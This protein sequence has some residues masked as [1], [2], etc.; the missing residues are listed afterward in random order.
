[1]DTTK[2]TNSVE[3]DTPRMVVAFQCNGDKE[4]YRWGIV[5]TMPVLSLIGY[6]GRVQAELDRTCG[7]Y[8]PARRECPEPAL[9]VTWDDAQKQFD[10]FVHPSVPLDS[11]LGMLEIVKTALVATHM[12]HAQAGHAALVGPDGRPL[13]YN[14]HMMR[15]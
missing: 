7:Q 4:M 2:F 1:M 12:A 6:I 11:L 3:Q 15:G 8:P 14:G 13:V 9:V 10:W 5:G